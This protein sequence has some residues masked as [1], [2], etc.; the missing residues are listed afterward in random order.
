MSFPHFVTAC[1]TLVFCRSA[2]SEQPD[3]SSIKKNHVPQNVKDLLAEHGHRFEELF[4]DFFDFVEFQTIML[5]DKLR[6]RRPIRGSLY[7]RMYTNFSEFVDFAMKHI[8]V[9]DVN[10]LYF[11]M[12]TQLK[13]FL[14][15][16]EHAV[17]ENFEN[18][19]ENSSY[20]FRPHVFSFREMVFHSD[21]CDY[22]REHY[23]EQEDFWYNDET[24]SIYLKTELKHLNAIN[25]LQKVQG[26]R[27]DYEKHI[28]NKGLN[29]KKREIPHH[30]QK[31]HKTK[32]KKDLLF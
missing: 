4:S 20:Y 19:C 29:K 30:F 25:R 9:M 23:Q 7:D 32:S 26:H 28:Y 18:Q 15:G 16:F 24:E 21:E 2:L 6:Y 31:A 3:D 12:S 17:T 14:N 8:I 1:I 11:G 27:Q 22:W 5:D 13:K 10:T